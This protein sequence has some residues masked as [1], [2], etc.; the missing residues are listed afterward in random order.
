[1][2]GGGIE[3]GGGNP[4]LIIVVVC[5]AIFVAIL[6]GIFVYLWQKAR[7]AKAQAKNVDEICE[8]IQKTEETNRQ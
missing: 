3:T 4:L 7:K 2:G 1:M 5:L 8:E 6:A